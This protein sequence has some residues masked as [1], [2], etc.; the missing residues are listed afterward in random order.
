MRKIAELTIGKR[1]YKSGM[2][3]LTWYFKNQP[4]CFIS[5][6]K[7][8][9]EIGYHNF[10]KKYYKV[11]CEICGNN[12]ITGNVGDKY[13][14]CPYCGRTHQLKDRNIIVDDT[15]KSNNPWDTYQEF[16]VYL[17]LKAKEYKEKIEIS[18]EGFV[19]LMSKEKTIED[20]Y[21]NIKEI[22]TLNVYDETAKWHK[23]IREKQVSYTQ[24]KE[25]GYSDDYEF[26]RE[27]SILGK[28]NAGLETK[29][30][31]ITR[32]L[33]TVKAAVNKMEEKREMSHKNINI[34]DIQE[35][36]L[37]KNMVNLA[38]KTRFWDGYNLDKGNYT[39]PLDK[40]MAEYEKQIP[41]KSSKN[42]TYQKSLFKIIGIPNIPSIRKKSNNKS[43][44]L[45]AA[46]VYKNRTYNE[47]QDILNAVNDKNIEYVKEVL[48]AYDTIKVICPNTKF[49]QVIKNTEYRDI[50][51]MYE[52]LDS[53]DIEKLKKEKIKLSQLHER[54]VYVTRAKRYAEHVYHIPDEIVKNYDREINGYHFNAVP[55]T[56][57]LISIAAA[58]NNCSATYNGRINERLQLVVITDDHMKIIALLEIDNGVVVQ[59][60]LKNNRRVKDEKEINNKVVEFIKK[61]NIKCKTNDVDMSPAA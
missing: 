25:I 34:P 37:L 26:L 30:M 59:A 40:T 51:R 1:S 32:F 18:A 45:K 43:N 50:M 42:K 21:A 3:S 56:K 46:V 48:S 16:P 2:Y 14:T 41:G 19:Y 39:S 33:T 7:D 20:D 17:Q 47:A 11:H 53:Y 28:I 12:F 23:E 60:K 38:H 4:T 31:T 44:L 58:L 5:T 15:H 61:S 24:D 10:Q 9:G 35:I 8:N 29:T 36:V 52:K 6:I 57:T 22:W 55:D 54:L 49:R 13:I 27:Y